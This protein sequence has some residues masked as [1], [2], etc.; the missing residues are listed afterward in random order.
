VL[1][2]AYFNQDS[3]GIR[4]R[5]ILKKMPF[6]E[7]EGLLSNYFEVATCSHPP[8]WSSAI[9]IK[10][11]ALESIGGFPEGITSGEDLLTWARLAVVN[12]IAYSTKAGAVYVQNDA[13]TY[14][15]K[16]ARVPENPDK[17]GKELA[18]LALGNKTIPG[19]RNYVA[20]WHKMR[21]SDFLRLGMKKESIREILNSLSFRLINIQPVAYFLLLVIPASLVS[22]IFKKFGNP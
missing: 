20:H 6:Q 16:P 3:R 21:A 2:T 8:L 17:V 14:N 1:A 7:D 18:T 13:H 9:A 5:I 22:N 11:S 10:K 15:D 12:D 4:K 19:I